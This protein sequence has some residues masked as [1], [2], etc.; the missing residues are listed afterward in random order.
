MYPGAH[1]TIHTVFRYIVEVVATNDNCTGH[2]CGHDL[3]GQ[4]TATD[5]DVTSERAFLVCTCRP[6]SEP[7]DKSRRYE[8]T[9]Q[10]KYH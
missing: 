7:E 10:R 5:G 4:N 8:W 9:H 6:E 1:F 2:F 3:T